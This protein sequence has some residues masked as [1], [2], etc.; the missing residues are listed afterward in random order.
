MLYLP[1]RH[2][3]V[4]W[5]TVKF[6]KNKEINQ[7][8]LWGNVERLWVHCV[9]IGLQVQKCLLKPLYI[10]WSKCKIFQ[11]LFCISFSNNAITF[12]RWTSCLLFVK[13][14]CCPVKEWKT[15]AFIEHHILWFMI[16]QGLQHLICVIAA[17]QYL[18]PINLKPYNY[19][20]N[21]LLFIS[22]QY[23]LMHRCKLCLK[24][25]EGFF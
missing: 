8:K 4:L 11:V 9:Y 10:Y 21:P 17:K 23:Y 14:S 1:K 19:P 15:L 18:L 20:G 12:I 3:T 25:N 7:I 16:I 13:R 5:I 22:L 2:G 6:D 24:N